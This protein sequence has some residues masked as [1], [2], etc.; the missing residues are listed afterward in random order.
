MEPTGRYL[1]AR[2]GKGKWRNLNGEN[3]GGDYRIR[4]ITYSFIKAYS[5]KSLIDAPIVTPTG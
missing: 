2:E 3:W 4:A 5:I 1:P